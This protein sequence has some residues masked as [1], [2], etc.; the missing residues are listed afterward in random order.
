VPCPACLQQIGEAL[1]RQVASFAAANAIPVVRLKAADRNI[2]L[3]RPYLER[4]AATGRS[5]VAAVGV[6]QEPQRVFIARKRDTDPAKP[7]Q[8]AFDKVDRRV[9]VYYFY[10]FDA[11]FGPAFV[12]VCTYCP[13][14]IKVWVNGH[15]WA[16][17]QATTAGL[18]FTALSNGFASCPDPVRLQEICDR[19]GPGAIGV[20]FARWLCRLPLPLQATD[21]DAG[22][23]WELSMAQIEVS[24]TIC[25]TQPRW[26]R[27]FFEALVADNLAVGRPDTTRDH[28]RPADPLHHRIRVRHQD[29]HPG[30]RG[31]CQRLLQALAPRAVPQGRTSAADRDR[32]QRPR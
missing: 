1:R 6:A 17:R 5:Q 12:K 23:W 21:R 13:W 15:E 9:T 8:V 19:L 4:A 10:L 31:H 18:A 7:P 30:R 24:R 25:F 14:P 26:A 2:E 20:F 27:A 32:H 3:M 11:D 22:W 16:K 29:R 28:L